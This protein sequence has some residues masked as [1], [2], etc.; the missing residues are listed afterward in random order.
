MSDLPAEMDVAVYREPRVVEIERRPVPDVGPDEVLLRVSHCG[1]CGTDLH[2]V[3]EGMGPPDSVGGHEYSGRI[4]ALG[5]N[6]RDFSLAETVVG[7]EPGGCGSCDY[8]K[9]G[10]PSLCSS[11]YDFGGNNVGAFAEYTTVRADELVRIP[12]GVS[13]REA[14]LTEPLAVALH[15][16]TRAGAS[17]GDR[18]LVTGAGP[19]GMLLIAALVARGVDDV[20]VSEP[21]SVRREGAERVG[22]RSALTPDALA[23]PPMPFTLVEAPFDVAFECSGNPSAMEAALAQ[24]RRAG[25]LVLVGTG[26]RRPRFDHNRILLNELLVTGAYCYDAGGFRAALA[27]LAEGTLPTQHL[28]EPDDVPLSGLFD[29]LERL[30]RRELAGKVMI[31]PGLTP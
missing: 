9:A 20:T 29:A 24:L 2:L 31:A 15:A 10:R 6:V 5:S 30:E 14:A 16:L 13:L 19:L 12:E 27:L 25:T 1:I 23:I 11:R 22:A 7:G 8:C 4:V 3:L 17:A 28:I 18:V 21:S 26:M